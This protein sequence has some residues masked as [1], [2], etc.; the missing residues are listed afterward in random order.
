MRTY[1]AYKLESETW[2]EQRNAGRHNPAVVLATRRHRF[3][4][5]AGDSD[6]IDVYREGAYL[7]VVT[8]NTGLGYAGIEVF[9]LNTGEKEGEVFFQVDYEIDELL[10]PRGIDLHLR[11]IAKRLAYYAIGRGV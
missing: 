1:H 8:V 6:R 4:L 9:G 2:D 11:N 5:G 10:G 7:F 3:T